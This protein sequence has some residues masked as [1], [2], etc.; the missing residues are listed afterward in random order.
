MSVSTAR[1]VGMQSAV[2]HVLAALDRTHRPEN[3][4]TAVA[5]ARE[6]MAAA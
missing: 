6:R 4:R 3:V 1:S 5:E 2:P